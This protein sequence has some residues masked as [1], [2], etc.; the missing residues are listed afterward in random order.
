[1]HGEV[2]HQSSQDI[3]FRCGVDG[4]TAKDEAVLRDV[5]VEVV[6]MVGRNGAENPA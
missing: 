4:W 2:V 3:V 6:G 5:E 1:M